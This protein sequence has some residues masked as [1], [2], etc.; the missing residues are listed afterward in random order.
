MNVEDANRDEADMREAIK[1]GLDPDHVDWW[2]KLQKLRETQPD[3]D[4]D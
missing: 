4:D 1:R 3:E 2:E